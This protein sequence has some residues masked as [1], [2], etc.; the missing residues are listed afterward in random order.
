MQISVKE[1]NADSRKMANGLRKSPKIKLS[2]DEKTYILNEINAIEADP[3]LFIFRDGSGSGYSDNRDIIFISSN[4]FPSD[5]ESLHPRDLMSVRAVLAH[6]YYG[7]RAYRGTSL[8]KGSW[9]DEFRASYIAA[10]SC[11]NL[12][13]E[14]RRYLILDAIERAKEAGIIIRYND[15]IRRVLYGKENG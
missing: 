4:V 8:E 3:D 10:K 2:D 14:D 12:T 7:H 9:N 15:F 5:D 1:G 6:E 11:P 13:D